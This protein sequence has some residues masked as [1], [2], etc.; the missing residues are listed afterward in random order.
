MEATEIPD[1]LQRL[2]SAF[3]MIQGA[4]HRADYDVR[5][6]FTPTDAKECCYKVRQAFAVLDE[7]AGDSIFRLFLACLL[8]ANSWRT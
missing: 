6:Q 8:F 5:A 3:A 2:A 1:E 7:C 4:R